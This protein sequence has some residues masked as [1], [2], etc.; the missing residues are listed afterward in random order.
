LIH[1]KK[2]VAGDLSMRLGH[3]KA[4]RMTGGLLIGGVATGFLLAMTVPT[5]MKQN[6]SDSWRELVREPVSTYE[7]LAFAAAPEDLTPVFWQSASDEYANGPDPWV[8]PAADLAQNDYAPMAEALPGE[9]LEA[10]EGSV[11]VELVETDEAAYSADAAQAAAADV[12]TVES[13][14]VQAAAPAPAAP[15]IDPEAA[16]AV[17]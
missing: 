16:A 2:V 7:P 8:D 6:V 4:L 5:T 15:L 11:T 13:A 9:L 14:G 17:S 10:R 12:Q 1:V 3:G